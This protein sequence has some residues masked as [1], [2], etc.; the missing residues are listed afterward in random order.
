VQYWAIALSEPLLQMSKLNTRPIYLK[1]TFGQRWQ[2]TAAVTADILL[3]TSL[4]QFSRNS[5]VTGN[6]TSLVGKF[7]DKPVRGKVTS[8]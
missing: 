8:S 5:S 3:N 7:S 6:H 4:L 1:Q 2:I